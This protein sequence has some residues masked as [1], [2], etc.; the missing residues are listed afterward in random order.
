M[1]SFTDHQQIE[2][3]LVS[4]I[5]THFLMSLDKKQLVKFETSSGSDLCR[6]TFYRMLFTGE[7]HLEASVTH[8]LPTARAVWGALRHACHTVH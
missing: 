6:I 2:E 5:Q 7:W 3:T 4:E 1:F 8:S